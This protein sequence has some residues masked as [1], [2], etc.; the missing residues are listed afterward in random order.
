MLGFM[1]FFVKL[2]KKKGAFK[3][4]HGLEKVLILKFPG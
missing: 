2:L 3:Q 4:P 1:D